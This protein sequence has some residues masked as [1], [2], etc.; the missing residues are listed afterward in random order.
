M[1]SQRDTLVSIILPVYNG[2]DYL[3]QSIESCLKQT[4]SNLELIIV[5][6]ASTDNSLNI[7]EEFAF[8]DRRV[9]IISN[10][11]N[12]NLPASLNIGHKNARGK[13]ITWTSHDNYYDLS[14]IEKL[15]DGILNTKADIIFSNFKVIDNTGKR[16]GQYHYNSS[17]SIVLENTVR[18]CFLYDQVVFERNE[19][20]DAELFKIED[21]DFWLRASRHS[22]IKHLPEELYN[23]RKHSE[24]LTA[25]KTI[26]QFY[27]KKDYLRN[28]E[29]MYFNFLQKSGVGN[30]YLSNLL[31]DLHLNQK[32]DVNF[33]LGNY[34]KLQ[35]DLD[36]VLGANEKACFWNEIDRKLRSNLI[37]FPQFGKIGLLYLIMKV[38]PQILLSYSKRK[39][40]KI[41]FRILFKKRPQEN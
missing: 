17:S 23:Y 1:K 5:N 6:D 31:K 27:Y 2:A 12:Q 28:V 15:L 7:A 24:S 16:I 39:S 32:L 3:S 4:Y 29:R 30:I 9:K 26:S 36:K 13:F 21:Y 37:R 34:K 18:A 38:R 22:T 19:G 41:I 35:K 10:S 11:I 14:A 8:K 25:G 20:Y 40:L 33:I